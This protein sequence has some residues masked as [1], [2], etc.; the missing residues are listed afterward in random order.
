MARGDGIAHCFQFRFTQFVV[1]LVLSIEVSVKLQ[2]VKNFLIKVILRVE[3]VIVI[4]LGT[5]RALL[6]GSR[7]LF[8]IGLL[9]SISAPNCSGPSKHIVNSITG[10]VIHH[11][12]LRRQ[13]LRHCSL[14][15][16]RIK[17]TLPEG[18]SVDLVDFFQHLV[19]QL[20]V[21]LEKF[22]R[23]MFQLLQ[24]LVCH[25][26]VDVLDLET[27]FDNCLFIDLRLARLFFTGGTS[28]DTLGGVNDFRRLFL[29]SETFCL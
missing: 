22:V 16:R 19:G 24:L 25:P 11:R 1:L 6:L 7:T 13:A 8:Q 26:Q 21:V 2:H 28:S 18:F 23:E 12:C 4:G 15:L 17:L 20:V 9:Q 3:K 5:F 29:V 27:H 10:S 14:C